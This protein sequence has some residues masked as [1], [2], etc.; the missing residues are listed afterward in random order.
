MTAPKKGKYLP[1]A[2]SYV[3][4]IF[5]KGN[6]TVFRF[7]CPKCKQ[8]NPCSCYFHISFISLSPSRSVRSSPINSSH[9]VKTCSHSHVPERTYR[10]IRYHWLWSMSGCYDGGRWVLRQVDVIDSDCEMVGWGKQYRARRRRSIRVT[11]ECREERT[12]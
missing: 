9:S 10:N 3:N 8:R 1:L 2:L 6:C 5:R 4:T 7:C 11:S 12:E